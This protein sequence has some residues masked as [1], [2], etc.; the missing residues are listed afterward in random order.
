MDIDKKTIL[1]FILIGLVLI[2][3]QTDFYQKTI[4]TE[5][6]RLRKERERQAQIAR[7]Q[8]QE[9]GD[10]EP[11]QE[12]L[13][14]QERTE[15]ETDQEQKEEKEPPPTS[16]R[17]VQEAQEKTFTVNTDLYQAT[18][19]SKGGNI[20]QWELKKYLDLDSNAVS[21]FPANSLQTMSIIFTTQERDSIN[22]SNYVFTTSASGNI[23]VSDQQKVTFT[24]DFG[25]DRRIVK[26]YIFRNG[27]YDIGFNVRFINFE[28]IIA[29]KR[30]SISAPHG[31]TST[32]QR[33]QDDMQYT[34]AAVYSNQNIQKGYKANGKVEKATGNID[35]A[36]VRTKY[37][38]FYI[39]PQT[40]K[41]DFVKIKGEK[42]QIRQDEEWKK[43]SLEIAMPYLGERQDGD[44]FM[45]YIGPLEYN[46][47]KSYNLG[48][49]DFMDFGWF[50]IKWFAKLI[51][52]VFMKM[53]TIIP[54]Y[55]VVI[56][57][58]AVMIKII[59]YPL[60]HKSY[61]SMQKMQAVQPKLKELQEKYKDNPQQLNKATM[62]LYK[63]EGVNPAGGCLPMLI[64]MPL[65][66][67]L[68]VVFRTTIELR[69][70]GFIWWINDLS[71]P[72]ALFTLP[73]SLPIYGD[74]VSLLPI[75]MM[76]TI[77]LQQKLSVTDPK[78]K[79][80]VYFM[81]IFLFL[82]FNRFPSGLNLYYALFNLLSIV[83]QKYL[84]PRHAKK[85]KESSSPIR[86]K[87]R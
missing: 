81:P 34:K 57:I 27:R 39:I 85:S 14:E 80:M 78:Q 13:Q 74:T 53:H 50:I 75:F 73:F 31:L 64:Q 71:A 22:T 20:L 17:P 1:A 63:K 24:L 32:E 49:Q 37:F 5:G 25:N 21:L 61:E 77:F 33:V 12:R 84:V 47:L 18:L 72:D 86:K 42:T 67:G 30:Y 43:Y 35:W 28:D 19:S 70:E 55:G 87:K 6:Y 29:N 59:V 40:R 11:V 16:L 38:A 65:L 10:Q 68:F 62:N 69:G 8:Q 54:N 52:I 48:L 56:L 45:L 7:Q 26:E 76:L 15:P 9:A 44:K 66:I 60:T 83:Q 82:L 23:N 2:I 58:F 46:T 51:L 36:A 4:D 41:S 79:F 3:A